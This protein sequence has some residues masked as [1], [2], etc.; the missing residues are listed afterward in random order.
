MKLYFASFLI[1]F[2]VCF[3]FGQTVPNKETPK[4]TE[5]KNLLGEPDLYCKKKSLFVTGKINKVILDND[6]KYV[7]VFEVLDAKKKSHFMNLN[8]DP[9]GK[10]GEYSGESIKSLLQEKREVKVWYVECREPGTGLY[11][12]ITRI[13]VFE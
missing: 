6:R 4:S 3:G 8:D 13:I 1:L 9:S 11:N 10:V 7:S 12:Y 2:F 5:L